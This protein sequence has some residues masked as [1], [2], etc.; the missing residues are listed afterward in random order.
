[1]KVGIVAALWLSLF[2][3]PTRAE[4]TELRAGG[5]GAATEILRVLGAEFGKETGYRAEIIASLGTSG[6]LSALVDG[7]LDIAVAGRALK[8]EEQ[9]KGL[10]VAMVVRTPFVLATSHKTPRGLAS[11]DVVR[12]FAAPNMAW[13]DGTPIRVILRPRSESDVAL[14]V[15][16]FPGLADAMEKSRQRPDIPVAATDQDNAD[17]AEST[18]GSLVGMTLT[19]LLL[20]KRNLRTVA[21]DGLD[22]SKDNVANGTYPYSKLL[23]FV[24]REQPG[25]VA[26]AFL[27]FLNS[28]TAHELMAGALLFSA[29]AP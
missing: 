9:A 14:M 27:R 1:M 10:K 19:Q 12:A 25:E 18:P 22:A 4:P 23:Y 7:H 16:L 13:P 5:T 17:L 15:S 8:A 2:L 21:I 11:A 24:T 3:S 6:G 28:A 26:A 20:E 29:R